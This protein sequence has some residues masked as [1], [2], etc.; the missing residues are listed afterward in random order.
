MKLVSDN[1]SLESNTKYK[2]QEF[3]IIDYDVGNL[4]WISFDQI[5]KI[6][7]RN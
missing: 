1:N 7:Q 5:N 4:V 6:S 3:E 2:H